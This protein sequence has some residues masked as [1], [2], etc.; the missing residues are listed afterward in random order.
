LGHQGH[1]ASC[2]CSSLESFSCVSFHSISNKI[3]LYPTSVENVFENPI[4]DKWILVDE[5]SWSSDEG[6]LIP[7]SLF[8]YTRKNHIGMLEFTFWNG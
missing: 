6:F 3:T 7:E 2:H 8:S 5:E 1:H 4:V